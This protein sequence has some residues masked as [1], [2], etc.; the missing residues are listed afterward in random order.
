M[1]SRQRVEFGE[2]KWRDTALC[3]NFATGVK[4]NE[5]GLQEVNKRIC[6]LT[7]H[8]IYD[9]AVIQVHF[10]HCSLSERDDFVWRQR[11]GCAE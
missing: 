10:S 4:H 1:L 2:S 3:A 6:H 5:K 11:G 7:E 9:E 8:I